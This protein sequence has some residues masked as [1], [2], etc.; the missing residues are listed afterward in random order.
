MHEVSE[1][2]QSAYFDLGQSVFRPIPGSGGEIGA[3]EQSMSARLRQQSRPGGMC[4]LGYTGFKGVC[5][6]K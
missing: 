5:G 3:T 2:A 1:T 6:K 4:M